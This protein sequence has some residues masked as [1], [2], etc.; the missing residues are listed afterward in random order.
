[1]VAAQTLKVV[2]CFSQ[3]LEDGFSVYVCQIEYLVLLTQETL[4]YLWDPVFRHNISL[5]SPEKMIE[6]A[7]QQINRIGPGQLHVVYNVRVHYFLG[8]SSLALPMEVCESD[9][10]M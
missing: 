10:P 3:L 8:D 4:F 5:E 6:K 9:D 7:L 2:A 1:M